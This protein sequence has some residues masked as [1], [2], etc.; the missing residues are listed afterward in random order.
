MDELL[1]R[2][3]VP[4]GEQSERARRSVQQYFA[5]VSGL[6]EQLGRVLDA[7][8]EKGIRDNTVVVYTSDHGEMMGSHGRMEKNSY[9][10]E[11]FQ[12][13]LLIRYPEKIRPR[14]TDM[15]ISTVDL[16]PTLL[17]MLGLTE[18][19]PAGMR[20]QDV[21]R[22]I[23]ENR[24]GDV[25]CALYHHTVISRGFKDD[26][27]TFVIHHEG[28]DKNRPLEAVLFD[29]TVDPYQMENLAAKH[30]EL[31]REF[32]E[33]LAGMLEKCCDPFVGEVWGFLAKSAKPSVVEI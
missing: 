27:Y 32:A 30:P 5:A 1:N 3:N 24:D 31:V 15:L 14:K 28:D 2:P 8:D 12:I 13:P 22:A 19:I 6:D 17:T 11:S 33:K 16:M 9:Y 20:G 23:L 4:K 26:R 7:I 21:G 18:Q 25:E 29:D 10:A